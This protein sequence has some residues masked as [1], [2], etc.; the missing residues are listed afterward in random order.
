MWNNIELGQAMF[1]TNKIYNYHCPDYVVALLRDIDR[2][3]KIVMW[4]KNQEEYDSPFDNTGNSFKNEIF[5]VHAYS[6]DDD[7]TQE[8]N[9]KYKDVEISWY[10]YLGRG[11]TINKQFDEK[12]MTEMYNDCMESLKEEIHFA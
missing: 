3:L 7:N 10:K 4:N 12:Y 8:Y 5:E 1:A 6:W 2:K 11:C 9:F